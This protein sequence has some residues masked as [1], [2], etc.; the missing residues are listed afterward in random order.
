MK[1]TMPAEWVTHERTWMAW[2][3]NNYLLGESETEAEAA[4]TTWAA[5]ANA[6]VKYEP[7]SVL[8]TSDQLEIARA[9]LHP[10]IEIV[11]ADFDDAVEHLRKAVCAPLGK[12]GVAV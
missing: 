10:S 6:V 8:A 7:V 3:P 2:P 1:L 4:R 12:A 5:V 9:Y 11:A